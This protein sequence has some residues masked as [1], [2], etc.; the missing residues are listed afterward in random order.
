MHYHKVK[1]LFNDGFS[2]SDD[3]MSNDWM[4][5][6]NKIERKQSWSNMRYCPSIV[7]GGTEEGHEKFQSG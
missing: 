6:N 7:P 1:Y 4:I 5:V 3:V 2:S